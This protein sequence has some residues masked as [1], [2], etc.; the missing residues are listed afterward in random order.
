MDRQRMAW[1]VLI[2]A[3]CAICLSLTCEVVPGVPAMAPVMAV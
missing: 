2:G 1:T 3:L